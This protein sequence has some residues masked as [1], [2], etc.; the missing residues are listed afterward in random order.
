MP[1]APNGSEPQRG[2]ISPGDRDALRRRAAE[3][4]G[5]LDE[6]RGRGAPVAPRHVSVGAGYALAFR[7][8]ADLI[9]GVAVGA[10]I[11]WVLDRQFG[12]SPW[13]LAVFV[14]FGFAAGLANVIRA[15]R[16]LEAENAAA[17]RAAPSVQDDEDEV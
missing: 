7:F 14:V 11:G 9:V 5:R 2:E 13:L 3:I 4:G 10:F 1:G 8:A 12:T 16:K 17:Q 15:A 6:V